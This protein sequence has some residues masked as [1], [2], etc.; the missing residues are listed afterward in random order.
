MDAIH[1]V[2]NEAHWIDE[3]Q[4]PLLAN[5]NMIKF[6]S[7]N[8]LLLKYLSQPDKGGQKRGK[9][10]EVYVLYICRKTLK[11]CKVPQTGAGLLY[12]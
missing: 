1:K 6:C 8:I 10:I 7:T 9:D 2:K 3:S 11:P 5:S 4:L 12:G